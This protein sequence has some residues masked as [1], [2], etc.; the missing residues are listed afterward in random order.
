MKNKRLSRLFDSRLFTFIFSLICAVGVWFAVIFTISPDTTQPI[1]NVP[2]TIN[3]SSASFQS[4]GLDIIGSTDNITVDVT[5]EGTRSAVGAIDRSDI[6]VT[7]SFSSVRG[8]GTFDLQLSVTKANPL[9]NFTI[10]SVEPSTITLTFDTAVSKK[11]TVEAEISGLRVGEGYIMQNA[12][13]SP[14]EVTVTG[15]ETEVQRVQRAAVK[16]E[17][18]DEVSEP[19][20]QTCEVVL[21]DASGNE[22]V[23]NT[24]RLDNSEVDVVVPIYKRGVLALDIEFTNVPDGFDIETLGY[25]LSETEIPIAA[26]EAVIENLRPRVIGYIDLSTFSIGQSY[27][28]DVELPN[29]VVNLDNV[30]QVTVTF[31]RENIASKR[32]NVNDIRVIN[33]PA[34]MNVTVVNTRINDVTVIGPAGDVEALLPTSVIALVDMSAISVEQ[35]S[36]NVPVTFRITSNHTTFVSGSYSVL[37]EVEPAG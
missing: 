23:S 31:P 9:D 11:V 12:V 4:L 25:A 22:I 30:E 13:V 1:R 18:N 7:P 19:V 24:L 35:G 2:V 33:R 14:G 10:V 37:I 29:G 21:Y 36:Y 17:V 8:A 15:P 27:T 28:F 26:S 34:N 32:V 20:R 6:I 5:V 3:T 16:V